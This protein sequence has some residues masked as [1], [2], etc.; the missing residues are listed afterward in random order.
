MIDFIDGK[1][2]VGQ[3]EHDYQSV[4]IPKTGVEKEVAAITFK[5]NGRQAWLI[6]VGNA[7]GVGGEAFLTW[8]IL[9]NGIP[10]P[11]FDSNINQWADPTRVGA[12]SLLFVKVPCESGDKIQAMC[13]NSDLTTDYDGTARLLGVYTPL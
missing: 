7:S 11:P 12:D 8:R 3:P 10:L 1:R 6:F 4:T 13:V 5:S 2:V 9:R